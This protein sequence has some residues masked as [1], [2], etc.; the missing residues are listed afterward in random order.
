MGS[1]KSSLKVDPEFGRRFISAWMRSDYKDL[2][3]KELGELFGVSAQSVSSWVNS[4]RYPFLDTGIKIAK[5]FH[6]NMDWLYLG[7]EP[8]IPKSP[9]PFDAVT[10]RLMNL[11]TDQFDQIEL[12]V[13]LFEKG[14]L[15][16]DSIHTFLQSSLKASLFP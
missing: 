7:R 15:T 13:G 10:Y 14:F 16:S 12:I 6:V 8:R 11:P 1:T 3:Q 2:N 9:T 5:A 4:T